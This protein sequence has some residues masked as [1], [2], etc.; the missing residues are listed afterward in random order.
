MK[1]YDCTPTPEFF[2]AFAVAQSR[3]AP[4]YYPSIDQIRTAFAEVMHRHE[5][6]RRVHTN[7]IPFP[8][9]PS[10]SPLQKPVELLEVEDDV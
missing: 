2:E 9:T 10:R 1:T 8:K 6:R 4:G 3:A 7:V 5:A